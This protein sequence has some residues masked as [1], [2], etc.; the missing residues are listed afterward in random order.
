MPASYAGSL[1]T[2]SVGITVGFG[3]LKNQ[4][5]GLHRAVPS[6][7]LYKDLV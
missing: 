3:T 6:A 2:L 4:V 7:S 5:A 1:I